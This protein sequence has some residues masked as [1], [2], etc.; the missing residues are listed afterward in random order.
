M[1]ILLTAE[2]I[3]SIRSRMQGSSILVD[4]NLMVAKANTVSSILSSMENTFDELQN[5]VN[6]TS[7]YWI[8][9]AGDHHRRMFNDEK[10]EI[11]HILLRLKE[12]PEDLKLMANNFETSEQKLTEMN[13]QLRSDYI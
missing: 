11:T 4:T 1:A 5:A 13:R 2:I 8:G 10:D 7:S 6:R 3:E 12:H 9:E